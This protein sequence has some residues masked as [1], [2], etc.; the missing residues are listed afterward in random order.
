VFTAGRA[1]TFINSPIAPIYK[2]QTSV[3][4]GTTTVVTFTTTIPSS[5][6]TAYVRTIRNVTLVTTT[7]AI[8]EPTAAGAKVYAV[9]GGY[10]IWQHEAGLNKITINDESAVY[11]SY[12]TCDLSWVGGTPSQ[13]ASPGINRRM[14]LRRLEPDF[15]QSG[16]IYMTVLGRKFAQ[17][18][19]ETSP[20]FTIT[21]DTEKLDL[22]L[23]FRELRMKFESNIID[24]NYE[25]GRTL[26]T[27]EFGDERP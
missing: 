9:Q 8:T 6:T 10:S 20:R 12:T 5:Q 15:V 14:H 22:R 17:S 2:V 3:F 21:P 7:A 11:S 19:V 4:N 26:I 23:E 13:D 24:G 25:M 16:D 27:A 1:V 18:P